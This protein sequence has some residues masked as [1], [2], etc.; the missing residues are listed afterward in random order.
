MSDEETNIG[1][2][3]FEQGPIRPPS[4]AQSLLLRLTRNCP[5]NRCSF[6]PVYKQARFSLRP[7]EHILADI[8]AVHRQLQRLQQLSGDRGESGYPEVAE[9]AA[10]LSESDQRALIAASNWLT[11]GMESI[12]LQDANSLVLKPDELVVILE[13]IRLR[14]PSVARITSYARS[15][16]IDRISVTD[17]E[18]I[19]DAGLNRIHIGLESGS[20]LVLARVQKGC[21][22]AQHIR[23]GLKVKQA[24]IQLSEYVIPGLGGRELS[25][26]HALETAE[27]LNRINPDFIR[28]RSLAIPRHTELFGQWQSG[29]FEK[30]GDREVTEEI[31]LFLEALEGI[32]STMKSDHILNLF[33]E[34]EGTFPED[35]QAMLGVIQRFQ[36]LPAEE[37]M[38]YQVG[39]RIGVFS[40]LD[41]L[42][43]PERRA[44]AVD[45]CTRFGVTPQNI[46]KVIDELMQRFI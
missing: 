5:W 32:S 45:V 6:C 17:L 43:R 44:R 3:G 40:G 13:Q 25:R 23:A 46:D 21:D 10:G 38:V 12:F 30:L 28:L 36:S 42:A 16:T 41:D 26:E 29:E 11:D 31:F 27:A 18:R 33:Q 1:Y 14:F 9:L 22:Q 15:Q 35:K 4:E 2:T 20:N 39:R 19:A 24:G 7:L 37:Q 8:D 34:L